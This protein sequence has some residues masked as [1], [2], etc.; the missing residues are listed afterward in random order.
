[1]VILTVTL[2]LAIDKTYAVDHFAL[3]QVNRTR[4][5]TALPGGKGINVA[6]VAS[7]LGEEVVA[8]GFVGGYNGRYI[9]KSLSEQTFQ[10]DLQEIREE[11]RL[12]INILSNHASTEILENGPKIRPEELMA[13]LEK[14]DSLSRK[15][16]VVAMSGSI[17]RGVPP[18]IYKQMIE[19][20]NRNGAYSVLDSSGDSFSEGLMGRPYMVKPN[21]EEL[22][23]VLGYSLDTDAKIC[24]TIQHYL[25]EGI[26]LFVLSM[27]SRGALVGYQGEVFQVIP[28]H[29]DAINPVGCG[30]ALVAGFAV[31]MARGMEIKEMIK[32]ATATAASN[33]LHHGAGMIEKIEVEA[34]IKQVKINKL[35]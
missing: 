27:G 23:K 10:C 25:H 31:G 28:P 18:T 32:L 35:M 21:I 30:D 11:S 22:E 6:R 14:F 19:I 9:G 1:M 4:K 16:R 29:I 2:N 5:V 8:T 17:P 20:A 7:I 33:A 24:A 13:F 3:T 12:C 34:F 15:A 26:Q